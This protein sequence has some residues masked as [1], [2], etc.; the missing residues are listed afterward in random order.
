MKWKC[1]VL[2]I[3]VILSGCANQEP[4]HKQTASGKPEGIYSGVSKVAVKDSLVRFCNNNGFMVYESNDS[5]VICG[6][7]REGGSAVLTQALIGNS[8][9]TTPVDK[10]RFTIASEEKNTKVWADM[11]VETQ[12]AMGQTQQMPLTDNQSKNFIQY[13]LDNIKIR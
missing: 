11:W 1:F 10:V 7:Q 5:S 4:L 3:M 2:T 13:V 6:K 9:S 12:M 8:Y